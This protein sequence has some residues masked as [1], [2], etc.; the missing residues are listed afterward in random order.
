MVVVVGVQDFGE[1]FRLDFVTHCLDIIALV[2]ILEDFNRT[3]DFSILD[4]V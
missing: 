4:K 1:V 2:E 3:Q